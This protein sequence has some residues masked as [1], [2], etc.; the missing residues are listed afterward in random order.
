VPAAVAARVRLGNFTSFDAQL[1]GTT[2]EFCDGT[3][4]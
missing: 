2:T 1:D 3:A 4:I